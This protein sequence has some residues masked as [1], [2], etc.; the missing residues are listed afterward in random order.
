MFPLSWFAAQK[1][2]RINDIRNFGVVDAG[3]IY[4]GGAPDKRVELE[5]LKSND[6]VKAVLDLR[7][8][9]ARTAVERRWCGDLGLIYLRSA[10]SDRRAPD[11]ARVRATLDVLSN[12]S[13]HPIFV[14]C[15]GGVHRT[16]GIVAAYR[17]I[18]Q[19][20]TAADAMK[21]AKR[22]H[23]YG[24]FGHWPWVEFIESLVEYEKAA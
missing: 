6:G 8:S 7:D 2:D 21:E 18:V 22:F 20:F 17:V 15:Q 12:P 16:G 5:A 14:H 10:F 1:R 4:R 19:G 24:A 3:R 13:N 11:I 23:L 9:L